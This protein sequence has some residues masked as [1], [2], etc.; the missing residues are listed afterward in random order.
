MLSS[1]ANPFTCLPS[2]LLI[3]YSLLI[4]K[5]SL[6]IMHL[7]LIHSLIALACLEHRHIQTANSCLQAMQYLSDFLQC[8]DAVYI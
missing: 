1:L 8:F 3:T 6:F 5:P 7:S 4:I 2:R